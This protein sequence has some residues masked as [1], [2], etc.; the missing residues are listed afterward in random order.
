MKQIHHSSKKQH[1]HVDPP[2]VKIFIE[3]HK[4]VAIRLG[5]QYN[6]PASVLLAQSAQETRWGMKVVGNAYFGIKGKSPS[7]NSVEFETHED[8]PH[9][10]ERIE[11]KF[12]AYE[13][14]G[15]A[16]EDYA[17]VITTN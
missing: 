11:A 9:G 16:A 12:R 6:I 5:K 17:R 3:A 7:G 15:D 2:Y 13:S 1:K 14:Y 8:T 10:S 4:D